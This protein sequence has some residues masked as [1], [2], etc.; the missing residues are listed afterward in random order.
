MF[1]ENYNIPYII[2][3]SEDYQSMSDLISGYS[4]S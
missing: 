2:F 4:L 3:K 1:C